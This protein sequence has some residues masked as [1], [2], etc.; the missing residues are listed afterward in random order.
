[1]PITDGSSDKFANFSQ[2]CQAGKVEFNATEKGV[3]ISGIPFWNDPQN[4][5]ANALRATKLIDA[6]NGLL[7]GGKSPQVDDATI[8]R[9]S[10]LPTP[11][12][13]TADNPKCYENIKA[14]ATAQFGCKRSLY[15][16]LCS[17]CSEAADG[18]VK[19]PQDFTFPTLVK[20]QGRNE[21]GSG[22]AGASTPAPT[23]AP[24]PSPT[25]SGAAAGSTLVSILTA[26]AA[27]AIAGAVLF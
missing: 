18:C 12:D 19:A 14:C 1:M 24:T 9:F 3:W 7:G 10:P 15:G 22:S 6:Y 20:P 25:K 27:S 4:A 16:Q 11:S 5:T 17:V 2:F 13:L 21:S 26:I 8:Q 23:P